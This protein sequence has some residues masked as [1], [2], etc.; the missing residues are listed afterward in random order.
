MDYNK[1]IENMTKPTSTTESRP[2]PESIALI[3]EDFFADINGV[4]N[5]SGDLS[6]YKGKSPVVKLIRERVLGVKEEDR[7]VVGIVD[8]LFSSPKEDDLEGIR[9]KKA[10][11]QLLDD[12]EK[13]V[14]ALSEQVGN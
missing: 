8:D 2:N 7:V 14:G 12:G 13:E 3:I 5:L 1:M 4:L 6:N 11:T 9:R 10:A